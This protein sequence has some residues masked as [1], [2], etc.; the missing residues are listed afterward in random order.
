VIESE[1]GEN[2]GK[3]SP[4]DKTYVNYGYGRIEGTTD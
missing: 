3:A 1:R 4:E 2:G